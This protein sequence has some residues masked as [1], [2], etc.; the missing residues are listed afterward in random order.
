MEHIHNCSEQNAFLRMPCLVDP[1]YTMSKEKKEWLEYPQYRGFEYNSAS[2]FEWEK[3]PASKLADFLQDWLFFGLLRAVLPEEI[4]VTAED[5][6]RKGED[7]KNYFT[8][9]RLAKYIDSWQQFLLEKSIVER[10]QLKEAARRILHQANPVINHVSDLPA[11]QGLRLSPS[12]PLECALPCALLGNA[13]WLAIDA[14]YSTWCSQ[15]LIWEQLEL[16]GWCP[17][18]V[19]GISNELSTTCYFATIGGPKPAR[20]HEQCTE[21]VCLYSLIIKAQH[22]PGCNACQ[23][24]ASPAAEV[25][26]SITRDITPVLRVI[27]HPQ[28]SKSRLE[29]RGS[30]YNTPYIAISHVWSDGLGNP[31]A[32]EV[33]TCQAERLQKAVDRVF[34]EQGSNTVEAGW[35]W[36]DTLCVP[37]QE[38]HKAQKE[39]AIAQ[40]KQIYARASGV[41]VFDSG[42]Y[43]CDDSI[44]ALEV[45]ARLRLSNWFRRLWTY[46]EGYFAQ[47][48]YILVGSTPRSWSSLVQT[49][50]ELPSEGMQRHIVWDLMHTY[51][52][53]FRPRITESIIAEPEAMESGEDGSDNNRDR[54]NPN[55]VTVL[56]ERLLSDVFRIVSQRVLS[57]PRDEAQCLSL[58]LGLD[59]RAVL[60]AVGSDPSDAPSEAGM[61]KVMW[62]ANEVAKQQP[63]HVRP[64]GAIPPS[65]IFHTGRRSSLPGY[66]W[67]PRSFSFTTTLVV[68]SGVLPYEVYDK[69]LEC[70]VP[71]PSGRLCERGRGLRV[72]FPGLILTKIEAQKPVSSFF[73]V[74]TSAA[75]TEGMPKFWRCTF[76]RDVDGQPWD[77]ALAPQS[78]DSGTLAIIVGGFT[79]HAPGT[80]FDTALVRI[81][82]RGEGG[83]YVVERICKLIGSATPATDDFEWV[84]NPWQRVEGR[85]LPL[86]QIWYVD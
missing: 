17:F 49:A 74:D 60:R 4:P 44:S 9:A 33:Y 1:L 71:R 23:R 53:L 6:I 32:N 20:D 19:A 73:I 12:M 42:L 69:A 65:I 43:H 36:L 10:T 26:S 80:S 66:R 41:L 52:S 46:Q 15:D 61:A 29:F 24:L 70:K 63:V 57:K 8:T 31:L 59:T 35:W 2:M 58:I 86:T 83:E 85:W 82:G 67:M 84:R 77:G 30:T 40:M 28:P 22:I 62:L 38:E 39:L 5:F 21:T 37:T 76:V 72:M 79:D 16:Q 45:L 34:R 25:A 64:Q 68:Y 50:R 54:E 3:Y 56:T 18:I 11:I 7:G 81:K 27:S 78:E 48:L 47:T 55:E 75:M 14:N 51:D 13:L